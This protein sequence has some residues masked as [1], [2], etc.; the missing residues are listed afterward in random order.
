[1]TGR[2]L[3]SRTPNTLNYLVF[4]L[5]FSKDQAQIRKVIFNVKSNT[6]YPSAWQIYESVFFW[7]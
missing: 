1:M 2:C 5:A 3:L 7:L 6:Y 4:Y